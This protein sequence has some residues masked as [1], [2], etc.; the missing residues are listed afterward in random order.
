MV[1]S[2]IYMNNKK[3]KLFFKQLSPLNCEFDGY[4][5]DGQKYHT[6]KTRVEMRREKR[7]S[8]NW[9]LWCI[10]FKPNLF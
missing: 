4:Q 10:E 7:K 2:T 8:Q 6:L 5:M 1:N 3:R 9:K